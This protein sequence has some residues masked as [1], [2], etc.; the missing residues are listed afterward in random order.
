M[1]YDDLMQELESLGTEGTRNTYRRHGV[2]GPCFGV[3]I[4]NLGALKKKIK[5]DHALAVELWESGNHDA[6]ILAMMIADP[7]QATSAQI[8]KWSKDLTSYPLTDAL[9]A[10]V[11]QTPVA[12]QK[13]EKWCSGNGE[14]VASMGWQ[15]LS[16]LAASD[17][18]LADEYFEPYLETIEREIHKNRNR[19]KY[20]MNGALINIG[21][22]NPHLQKRAIEVAGT[23]GRVEVDHGETG[24]KT[25]DAIEYIRKTEEHK[26]KKKA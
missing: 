18:E 19:V 4:A 1:N 16:R 17:R 8:E 23:I 9:A 11:A 20:A 26:A 10:C 3:S 15:I 13:M 5:V 12:R 22:R 25:P 2:E 7:K 21:L 14:W 24:C 6:R